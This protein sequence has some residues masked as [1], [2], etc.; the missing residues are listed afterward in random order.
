[1]REATQLSLTTDIWTSRQTRGFI[2]VTVHYIDNEWKMKS[3][4]LETARL[5]NDHTA[6]NIAEE[7]TRICTNW[8][9]LDKVSTIVTDNGANI[10]SAVTKYM[11]KKTSPMLCTH[12][13]FGCS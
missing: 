2:T 11:K 9:I 3:A 4:V 13:K 1:M 7:L 8:D 12:T 5:K 6:E 10:V